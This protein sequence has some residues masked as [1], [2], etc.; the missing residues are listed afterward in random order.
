MLLDLSA[1]AVSWGSGT[2]RLRS[3]LGADPGAQPGWMLSGGTALIHFWNGCV[4]TAQLAFYGGFF[5]TAAT[6]IYLL[7]RRAV[8]AKEMDE[9][10]LDDEAEIVGLAPL[11]DSETGVPEMADP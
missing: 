9:I 2:L 7:L 10:T 4:V 5:W 8:D 6:A 3:I 1:W 11:T